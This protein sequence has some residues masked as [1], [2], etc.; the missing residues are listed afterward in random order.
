MGRTVKEVVEIIAPIALQALAVAAENLIAGDEVDERVKDQ[1]SYLSDT[2]WGSIVYNDTSQYITSEFATTYGY[3]Y[4]GL[5]SK[6]STGGLPVAA[7]LDIIVYD[8]QKGIDNIQDYLQTVFKDS[9][10]PSDSIEVSQNLSQLFAD[11]FKE[12]SLDWT[13][14][15]KRFNFPD[16]MIMDVYMVT[17]SARDVDNNHAGVV[18]YCFVAYSNS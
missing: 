4:E 13:P 6:P 5:R 17:S 12:E 9:I 2:D 15:N 1:I 8:P 3:Y 18:T 16:N 11:R 14:F 10:S 7:G